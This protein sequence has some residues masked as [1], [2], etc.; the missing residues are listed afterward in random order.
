MTVQK[1]FEDAQKDDLESV[2]IV[3]TT[4][5]GGVRILSHPDNVV[6]A[7]WLLSMGQYSLHQFTFNK[8]DKVS[9]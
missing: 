4:K 9:K 2:V 1:V 5:G 7:N 6:V 8:D 3:G